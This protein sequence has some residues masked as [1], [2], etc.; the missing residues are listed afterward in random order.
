MTI[1]ISSK[2]TLKKLYILYSI[3][4]IVVVSGGQPKDSAAH[5]HA[6]ILPQHSLPSRL[7]HNIEQSSL[8]YTVGP[9]WLFILNITVCTFKPILLTI[10][11]LHHSP[12]T[13]ISSFSKF[14]SFFLVCELSSFALLYKSP[15]H[16]SRILFILQN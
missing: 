5:I 12:L 15:P 13:T 8:C 4:N 11:S 6:S 1:L 14:V 3:N 7:S 9:C 10:S 2:V 16:I